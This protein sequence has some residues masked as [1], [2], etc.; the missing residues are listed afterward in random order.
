MNPIPP[1]IFEIGPFEVRWYG[2]LIMLGVALGAYFAAR[3]ANKRGWDSDHV[4]NAL[5][6]AVIM[7][8]LGARLYHVFSTP[9]GCPPNATYACGWPYYKDHFL[10]AFKIWESGGFMGLGIYGAIVGG[11]LGVII[12]AWWQHLNPLQWLDVGG[13][14]LAFGQFIGRWGNFINQELYG[15]PTG[16]DWF[17]LKINPNLP[18][19]PL[20]PGTTYETRF[21]P[22]FLYESLWSLGVFLLLYN[23]HA[24]LPHR[25][26]DGDV[27]L[28]YL[29]LY[30]LGRFFVEFF[31]PD[32]W[33]IGSLATAQWIAIGMV[34]LSSGALVLR[35]V[36]WDRSGAEEDSRDE[37]SPEEETSQAQA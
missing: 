1:V 30:P 6:L 8:I 23:I 7:A 9:A 20:P 21:H 33:T 11:A 4:W 18:H 35:H 2:V 27:F 24:R 3:L 34:V 15:P 32:A 36:F 31:R 13:A 16:S 25:L 14:G 26:R 12:Y 17:G 28:G 22:T 29:I 37:A 10:D 5:F 19:Q